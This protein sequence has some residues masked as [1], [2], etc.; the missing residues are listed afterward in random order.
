MPPSQETTSPSFDRTRVSDRRHPE[1]DFERKTRLLLGRQ[2]ERL[3]LDRLLDDVRAGASA[4]LVVRGEAGVGK[5]ALLDYLVATSVNCEVVRTAGIQSEMELASAALHQVCAP[6][7]EQLGR[8][9]VPQQEA[10]RTAFGISAGTRPDRFIVGLGVLGLLAETTRQRPLICLIDDAQWLDRASAQVLAF[11]ARRL[12]AESVAMIFA[13][14]ESSAPGNPDVPELAGLCE[15]L[16]DGLPEDDARTLFRSVYHGPIDPSVL[17]RVLLEADGN[18][19]ALQEL[20]R[21]FTMA[22]LAGGFG[23]GAGTR[24]PGRI[25]ESFRR[26]AAPLPADAQQLLLI[27]AAEP[28]GDLALTL[29]AADELGVAVQAAVE[30]AEASGLVEFGARIRFRHPLVRSAIY[31]AATREKQRAVHYALAQVTDPNLDPDRRAWHR[32][33]AA[34]APDEDVAAE[35]ERS[36]DR[37][38]ARGGL[39]AA[40]A[41]LERS[42][43]L[44]PDA[45]RRGQRALAAAHAKLDAGEPDASSRMLAAARASP[46]DGLERAEADLLGVQIAFMMNRGSEAPLPLREVAAQLEEHDIR[47]ARDTY[48]EALLAAWFAAHLATGGG[49]QEVADAAR[50]APVPQ[51]PTTDTDVLIDALALRFTDG[52]QSAVVGFRRTLRNFRD[53]ARAGQE[54]PSLLW[55]VYLNLAVDL[56]DD[57]AF[58]DLSGRFLLLAREAGALSVLP[59]A[60]TVR[61]AYYVMAGDIAE[62]EAL[63][64][65]QQT[66]GEVTG[67]PVA[68]YGPLLAAAWRGTGEAFDVIA[69][70]RAENAQRGEGAGVVTAGWSQAL[71]CNSLGRYDEALAAAQEVSYPIVE[72]GIATRSSL[73]ELV[74]AAVGAHRP[75]LA[76]DA[77]DRLTALT[78]A[79]GTD[80]ALGLEAR[81]RALLLDGDAAEHCHREAIERLARTRIRSDLARAILQYGEWLRRQKRRIDAREQLR[82]AHEMFTTMGAHAFTARAARELAATGE[83]VRRRTVD[84]VGELTAQ[85]AQIARLVRE[86]LPNAEVAA[87]LFISPRTVEWHLSRVFAKLHITSRRQLQRD[88]TQGFGTVKTVNGHEKPN[89]SKKTSA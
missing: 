26:Q 49:L 53:R 10:L 57:D 52:Y 29:R 40:A 37:A 61:I 6:M 72:I 18:P 75:D 85:E 77:F 34:G 30:R 28:V 48:L 36:A 59:F 51:G 14:R 81:C 79:S 58:D 7:L 45:A 33:Q 3:V 15:L 1:Y 25:E 87:R 54:G 24:P 42:T 12:Q 39:A 55:H 4:V 22:E 80:W 88:A 32:A 46:L 70:V 13:V 65:E 84:A 19:L 76:K 83:V 64:A 5:T 20:P 23:S 38:Q 11:V 69:A 31:R 66:V 17:D 68:T 82:A 8:L 56:W 74:T 50:H 47:R 78:Q 73:I 21:G 60:L 2:R 86:G 43:E 27:A 67:M 9:P 41:F 16:V 71:L 89:Y 62:A 63:L 35:L 44:T